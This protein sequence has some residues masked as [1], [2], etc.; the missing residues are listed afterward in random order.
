MTAPYDDAPTVPGGFRTRW[1]DRDD[2]GSERP[3]PLGVHGRAEVLEHPG[4]GRDTVAG[5]RTADTHRPL[6][7]VELGPRHP[8]AVA[9]RAQLVLRVD[10]PALD[11]LRIGVVT[12]R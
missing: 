10:E 12:R 8:V 7:V 4:G 11:E 9:E 5:T 6:R 2:G 3:R 1:L